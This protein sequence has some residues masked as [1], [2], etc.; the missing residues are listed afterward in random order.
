MNL[1]ILLTGVGFII[2]SVS[3]LMMEE[4]YVEFRRNNAGSN[5]N[6]EQV[7]SI[8]ALLIIGFFVIGIVF[9]C[10]SFFYK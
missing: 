1:K 7:R 9:I 10:V 3:H 5:F 2:I 8:F 4:R 6:E